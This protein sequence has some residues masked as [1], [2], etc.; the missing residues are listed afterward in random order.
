[1]IPLRDDLP[2]RTTPVVTVGLIVVNVIVFMYE[3]SLGPAA[4]GFIFS[5]G[6]I[7]ANLVHGLKGGAPSILAASSVLTSMFLH[8]GFMHLAGNMLY[9]WIFGNNIEDVMGHA[10]FIFFYLICGVL[11]AY[12]HAFTDPNSH[13]PMVGASGAI[14]GVLGAYLVL[15]PHAKVLTLVPIG[16]FIQIIHVPAVLVLGIWFL[17]QFFSGIIGFSGFAGGQGGGIAWFA[18]I[19]GFLAGILLIYPFKKK[20]QRRRQGWY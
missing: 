4:E 15:F 10:R 14:S 9:L 3:A 19:G 7:P 2:T 8:G 20:Q 5:F 6:A 13:I 16:F 12:A 1:M 18:H 11:A 17:V